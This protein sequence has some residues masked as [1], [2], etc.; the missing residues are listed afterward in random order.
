MQ[1]HRYGSGFRD[2]CVFI[3]SQPEGGK[4]KNEKKPKEQKG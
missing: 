4:R 3:T 1:I 2:R